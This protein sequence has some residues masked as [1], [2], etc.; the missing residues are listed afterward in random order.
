MH[1]VC[2]QA[3]GCSTA[4]TFACKFCCGCFYHWSPS[5]RGR[6]TLGLRL[7]CRRRRS[8]RWLWLWQYSM[9]LTCKIPQPR[10]ATIP[11]GNNGKCTADHF[12]IIHFGGILWVLEHR[13]HVEFEKPD[14]SVRVNDEVCT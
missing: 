5:P 4:S 14:C 13:T 7:L 6:P 1:T 3:C 9:E 10:V 8:H 2:C 11:R 12:S